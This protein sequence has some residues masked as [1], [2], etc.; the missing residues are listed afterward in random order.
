[1]LS[2]CYAVGMKPVYE[3]NVQASDA[4]VEIA[5]LIVESAEEAIASSSTVSLP[6][7]QNEASIS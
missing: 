3:Q 6:A 5:R 7:A 2:D 1:M 4:I